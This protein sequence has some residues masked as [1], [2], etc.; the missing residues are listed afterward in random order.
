MLNADVGTTIASLTNSHACAVHKD[1]MLETD[2]INDG[3][4]SMCMPC[5]RRSF[6]FNMLH[7]LGSFH[8]A[9]FDHDLGAMINEG[10]GRIVLNMNNFYN[11]I[12]RPLTHKSYSNGM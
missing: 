1:T 5:K 2:V 9:A 3:L 12:E 7:P 11:N 6:A 10:I 8:I 4:D